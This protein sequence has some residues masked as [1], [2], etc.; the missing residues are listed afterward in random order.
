[1]FCGVLPFFVWLPG[2]R[3]SSPGI[4]PP[5]SL[6]IPSSPSTQCGAADA[7]V[8]VCREE[9]FKLGVQLCIL[10]V[11][12]FGAQKLSD[13][14]KA[15]WLSGAEPGSEPVS[16]GLSQP[17]SDFGPCS[18]PESCRAR[19]SKRAVGFPELLLPPEPQLLCS[20]GFRPSSPTPSFFLNGQPTNLEVT[21]CPGQQLA[22]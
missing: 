13:L 10:Q 6:G 20:N 4:P 7:S 16:G 18:P 17:G 15:P 14:L 8:E 22:A 9:Q 12:T 19:C 21:H 3:A 2:S 5:L 1:M 11:R